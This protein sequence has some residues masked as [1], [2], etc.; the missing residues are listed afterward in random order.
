MLL[1]QRGIV[2]STVAALILTCGLTCGLTRAMEL[3]P[4]VLSYKLPDQMKWRN[5]LGIAPG[6]VTSV[7][8]GDPT[9]PGLYVVMVK[10][11]AGNHF[12]HPHFHPHDRFITVI[13]GTWWVGTGKK[14]D[15]DGTL[16]MPAGTFVTHYGGQVHFDGAKDEDAVLVITGEGPETPTPAEDK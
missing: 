15:P 16:P 10:W 1:G 14:F 4:A 7:V 8:A 5:P 13:K 6:I 12:S 2:A 3:D 9:K 11:L